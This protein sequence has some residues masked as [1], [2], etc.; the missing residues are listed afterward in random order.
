MYDGSDLPLYDTLDHVMIKFT[1]ADIEKQEGVY[2]FGIFNVS[3]DYWKARGNKTVHLGMST[4]SLLWYGEYA[5]GIPD[6]VL[7]RMPGQVQQRSYTDNKNLKYNVADANN[8]YYQ[9]RLKAFLE[10]CDA[11]FKDGR[12]VE[13]IDLRGYGMWGEWHS[14]YK[15]NTPEEKRTGLAA[16]LKIWSEAFP[17]NWLA[18]AYSYDPDDKSASYRKANM[19]DYFLENSSY[20]VG[21]LYANITWRR[22]GAGGAVQLNERTFCEEMFAPLTRGPFISEGAGGYDNNR[23]GA[24]KIL[25]DGLTLHPNYFTIIGWTGVNADNFVSKEPDLYE[26]GANNMGYRLLPKKLTLPKAAYK[27]DEITITSEW[28]NLAV[29]RAVRDYR[30]MLILTDAEGNIA[31]EIDMGGTG[32]DKWIK[33]GEYKTTNTAIVPKTLKTGEYV[34]YFALYSE[35]HGEYIALPLKDVD[36][37]NESVYKIGSIVIT[38]K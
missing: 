31:A 30:L 10:A 9:E 11:H 14:G 23:Q 13:I 15:Y 1:W 27:N 34:A 26:Y 17:D 28:E 7:D 22:D 3:Y 20:D 16:V 32:C 4:E 19:Y 38:K 29:G 18:L 24:E 12:P 5:K 21:A 25:Y 8:A 37:L 35:Y 2:D 33:G 36:T 6:Y